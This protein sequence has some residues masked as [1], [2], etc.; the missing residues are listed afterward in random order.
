MRETAADQEG[1]E[2]VM[3]ACYEIVLLRNCVED[4]GN[5]LMQKIE[6]RYGTFGMMLELVRPAKLIEFLGQCAQYA[7]QKKR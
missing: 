7:A 4:D 2:I 5:D 3:V 1:P 6:M